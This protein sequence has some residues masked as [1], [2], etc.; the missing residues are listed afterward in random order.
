MAPIACLWLYKRLPSRKIAIMP[1]NLNAITTFLELYAKLTYHLY[2]YV[3]LRATGNF[4]K[5]RTVSTLLFV[6]Y[7]QE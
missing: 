4:A 3:F 7:T 5:Y 2:S 6:E 1:T